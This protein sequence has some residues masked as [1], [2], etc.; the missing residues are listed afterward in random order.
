MVQLVNMTRPSQSEVAYGDELLLIT[1]LGGGA[2]TPSVATANMLSV[3]AREKE[4]SER[5]TR[6]RSRPTSTSTRGR[7]RAVQAEREEKKRRKQAA[8]HLYGKWARC[9]ANPTRA[10][11][12]R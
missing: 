7:K 1:G 3:L 4:Q 2:I 9:Y 11:S 6:D 8:P 12:E 10:S 5:E